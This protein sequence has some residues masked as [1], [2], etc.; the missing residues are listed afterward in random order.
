VDISFDRAL[1]GDLP[2]VIPRGAA[3][4]RDKHCDTGWCVPDDA[5]QAA[6][7][8]VGRP[9]HRDQHRNLTALQPERLPRLEIAQSHEPEDTRVARAAG[10]LLKL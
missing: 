3:V 4:V 9:V 6:P 8:E 7:E 1:A 10:M 5:G 2:N